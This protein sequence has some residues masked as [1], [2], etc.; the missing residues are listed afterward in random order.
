MLNHERDERWAYV[1]LAVIV[2]GYIVYKFVGSSD[3]TGLSIRLPELNLGKLGK[4]LPYLAAPLF[5]VLSEVVRRRKARAVREKW[6]SR[7]RTEGLLR[8]EENLKV[9]LTDG[10]RGSVQADVRLTRAALYVIDS[11]GRRDPMRFVR[12]IPTSP[13]WTRLFSRGGR[14]SSDGCAFAWAVRPSSCSNSKAARARPGGR[15]CGTRW[16]SRRTGNRPLNRHPSPS[17]PSDPAF[18]PTVGP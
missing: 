5:A 18:D 17:R 12:S 7:V 8:E 11:S 16:G 6:E 1:A 14:P 15:V 2:V 4:S 10:A 9:R 13:F 3:F